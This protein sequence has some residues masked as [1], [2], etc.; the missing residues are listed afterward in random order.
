MNPRPAHTVAL[1]AALAALVPGALITHATSPHAQFEAGVP[2]EEIKCGEDLVLLESPRGTPACVSTGSAEIL[3]ARGFAPVGAVLPGPSAPSM[4]PAAS[5]ESGHDPTPRGAASA[6]NRFAVGLYNQLSGGDG[7]IFFSPLS[8]YV[9]FSAL[10]EGAGGETA[11]Q[12]RRVLGLDA[13]AGARRA[14]VGGLVD[15]VNRP[16][17]DSTL[18]MANALWVDDQLLLS[19]SYGSAVRDS[20]MAHVESLDL[21]EGGTGRVNDWIEDNTNGM[22]RDVVQ[23]SHIDESTRLVITNAIY[24]DA[25]WERQFPKH[26]TYEDDFWKNGMESTRADFMSLWGGFDHASLD[27]FQMVRLPYKGERLSM[28]VLLPD[29]RDGIGALEESVTAPNIDRWKKDL[30]PADLIVDIPRFKTGSDYDLVGLLEDL[31]M[32]NVFA[33][34]AADLSGIGRDAATGMTLHVAAALHKAFVD[35]HE[36][37]TEAAAAT[38]VAGRFESSLDIPFPPFKANRP[39][40]FMIQDDETGALL[41]MGRVT[42]PTVG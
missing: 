29:G 40:M 9:A 5:T 24:L 27:G 10:Y 33:P 6:S 12:M 17:P 25:E 13:D 23:E 7:N 42:D 36:E 26:D 28:L 38:V 35:V 3:E 30:A 32:T 2:L 41:F 34:G 31:G 21:Q 14:A 37:G 20:Y 8:I 18:A 22:I 4:M 19:G 16:D 15:H 1:L 11:E 39:F